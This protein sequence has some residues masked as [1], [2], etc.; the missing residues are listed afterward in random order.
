MA[1]NCG[2]ILISPSSELCA[3]EN[4]HDQAAWLG[5][6]ALARRAK[7]GARKSD[8]AEALSSGRHRQGRQAGSFESGLGAAIRR[9]GNPASGDVG[10]AKLIRKFGDV[11]DDQSAL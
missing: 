7:S 6:R 8:V 11:P 3:Q 4:I 1:R 10:D 5:P 2:T 9:S